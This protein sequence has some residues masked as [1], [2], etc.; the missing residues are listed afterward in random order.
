MHVQ[1]GE[2]NGLDNAG[3]RARGSKLHDSFEHRSTG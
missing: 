3:Y 1:V 2:S